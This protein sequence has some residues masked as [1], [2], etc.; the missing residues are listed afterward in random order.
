MSGPFASQFGMSPF[1]PGTP[2]DLS[3]TNTSQTQALTSAS[4]IR[5]LPHQSGDHFIRIKFV[6]AIS[7]IASAT[8]D[9][10]VSCNQTLPPERIP[11]PPNARDSSG[12]CWL[13][14]IRDSGESSNVAFQITTG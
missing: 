10:L 8:T 11:V 5:L 13:A 2:A 9:M 1:I 6:N 7:G 3:A 4:W 12:N 14:Y